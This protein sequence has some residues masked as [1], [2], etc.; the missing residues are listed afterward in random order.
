M[1]MFSVKHNNILLFT[2]T[3]KNCASYI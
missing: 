1:Y 2:L 3:L